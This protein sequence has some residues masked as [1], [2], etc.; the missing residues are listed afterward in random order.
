MRSE[1]RH[2]TPLALSE[3]GELILRDIGRK[4]GAPASNAKAGGVEI[5]SIRTSSPAVSMTG[6][7]NRF[8]SDQTVQDVFCL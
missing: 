4:C 5:H 8:V 3:A 7:N 6:S 1:L 2:L